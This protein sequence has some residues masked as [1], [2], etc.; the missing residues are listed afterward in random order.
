MIKA[1][2]CGVG[3]RMAGRM[4]H[5]IQTA[6]DMQVVGGIE[7]A[8]HPAIGRDVGEVVGLGNIGVTVSADLEGVIEQGDVVIEFTTP[9]A[10]VE[11][12][13]IAAAHGKAMVIGTTGLEKEQLAEVQR[14]AQ[15]IPCFMAPNMSVGVNVMFKLLQDAARLLGDEYDVEIIEAHHRYKVDA[16]SGTAVK[17][18]ELLAEALGRNLEEVGVFGRP[19]GII[20][21]RKAKE[22]GIQA[23]RAGD[24]V[25]EHTTIFGGLGERLEI[26]H[27]AQSRDNFG[28]GALRAARWI[29][30]QPPGLYDMQ[31]LLGLK[32]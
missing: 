26:T 31:D 17:M 19:R 20:G 5:L 11:H 18:A 6:E 4:V 10:T 13:R 15:Q 2:V 32:G 16:P 21:E 1:I 29:L 9:A 3:G 23:I 14:L 8:D 12:L 27:R 24:I 30:Q 25:G 28:R 7:R 22:I